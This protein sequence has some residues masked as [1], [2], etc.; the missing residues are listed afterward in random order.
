MEKAME[1]NIK[2]D[3]FLG[4]IQKTLGIVEKKT[5]M[6]ILNNLLI[7]TESNRIKVMATD[8]EIGIVSDYEAEIIRGGDITLSAKKLYEMVREIQGDV[9][10]VTKN[11]RD[12]V[13][14]TC[15]K[16]V[17]RSPGIPAEDYPAVVDPGELPLFKIKAVVLKE[18]IRKTVFAI[19][20]DEMRKNLNGV[21]LETESA[22]GNALIRMVA[23]DGHRL[24]LINMD[25]G[26]S[27]FLFLDKGVIIPR[28]GIGEIRRLVEDLTDEVWIG[29]RQGMLLIKTDHTLLKVSLIDG[30]YPDY[31]RVIPVERGVLVG[32]DRDKFLHALRRM[33]VISSERYNGVII[34]LSNERMVL[35]STNPDVGEANDEI[36]VTYQG[37][38]RSVGYNVT[39]L[40]DAVEV[41]DEERVEFEIGAGMKPGVIRAVDNENYFC[42]VMP[43]KL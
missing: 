34:S 13:I 43:L 9:I 38:E 30:E 19:S 42:I 37:E 8:R 31:K 35:S 32:L 2:R 18:M 10:H 29:V 4:A 28:K 22:G 16:A 5:T 21:F 11:E 1:F 20:T 41:I 7:R 15:Q 36:E 14:L 23:T 12:M 39:Y 3:V 6:P 27:E 40:A 26:E 33:S 17:Y 24:S 25:T